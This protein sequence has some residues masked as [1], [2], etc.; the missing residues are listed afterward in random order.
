MNRFVAIVLALVLTASACGVPTDSHPR[1]ASVADL[2]TGLAPETNATEEPEPS[3]IPF[4]IFLIGADDRLVS[5]TRAVAANT[6]SVIES[7]IGT[8]NPEEF[9]DLLEVQQL[10]SFIPRDTVVISA[11][12]VFVDGESPKNIL[13]LNLGSEG[14]FQMQ[15]GDLKLLALAQIVYTAVGLRS[16]DGVLLQNDGDP[17]ALPTDTGTKDKDTPVNTEDYASLA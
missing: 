17:R 10:R 13:I 8:N 6:V 15:E 4:N 14:F 7:V 1:E 3:G 5:V 9:D 2:P 12:T 11:E 16:V